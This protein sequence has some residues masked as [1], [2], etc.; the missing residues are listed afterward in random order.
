MRS[1]C[2]PSSVGG[3]D[4]NDCRNFVVVGVGVG[5]EDCDVL[6]GGELS[7]LPYSSDGL[8]RMTVG[9][10]LSRG[11]EETGDGDAD[12]ALG[13]PETEPPPPCRR[14]NGETREPEPEPELGPGPGLPEENGNGCRWR[15]RNAS[16][17]WQNRQRT[18]GMLR[19]TMIDDY[20]VDIHRRNEQDAVGDDRFVSLA[21]GVGKSFLLPLCSLSIATSRK[22]PARTT[23]RE[24]QESGSRHGCRSLGRRLPIPILVLAEQASL[25]QAICA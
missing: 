7:L 13:E 24:L 23:A 16:C 19:L 3:R 11:R 12:V 20:N 9:E 4:T 6:I 15:Q 25:L 10:P 21:T 2:K 5:V 8:P 17:A 22:L 1:F 18:A 14:W